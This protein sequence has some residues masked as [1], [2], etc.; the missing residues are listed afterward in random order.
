MTQN[1]MADSIVIPDK[2]NKNKYSAWP[3]LNV[4]RL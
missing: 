1:I 2:N 4:I 3:R